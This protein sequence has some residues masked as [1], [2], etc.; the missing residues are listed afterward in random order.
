[1]NVFVVNCGSS[2]L[3]YQLINT[4]TEEVIAKGI[5]ER[6]GIDGKLKHKPTGKEELVKEVAMPEHK[7]AVSYVLEALTDE[8][9]GVISDLSEIDAVGHRIVHGGE[10]FASSVII[11]DE[12]LRAIEECNDLAPLH[13]PANLIGVVACKELMPNVPM[14]GVFDTAFHQKCLKRH[15]CMVWL[16]NTMRITRFANMD[17][18]EHRTVLFPN[19]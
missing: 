18:T 17:F 7:T 9:A 12:V 5:C 15:I 11:T 14:V 6:I 2:S 13:N 10:K 19:V 4:D 3:K 16:M 1:M 8:V